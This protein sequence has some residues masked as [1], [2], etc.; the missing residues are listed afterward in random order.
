MVK[1]KRKTPIR[2]K[3]RRHIREGK[4]VQSY[5]RG[6]GENLRRTRS[7]VVRSRRP[8]AVTYADV[9]PD[10]GMLNKKYGTNVEVFG[11]IK[12]RGYSENDIDLISKR[13]MDEDVAWKFADYFNKKYNKKTDMFIPMSEEYRELYSEGYVDEFTGRWIDGV[14]RRYLDWMIFSRNGGF[15][16]GHVSDK[17]LKTISKRIKGLV[18]RDAIL[19]REKSRIISKIIELKDAGVDDNDPRMVLLDQRWVDAEKK[20]MELE[21]A[22]EKIIGQLGPKEAISRRMAKARKTY[23]LTED[24]EWT[25]FEAPTGGRNI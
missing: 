2:H 18:Y 20:L 13:D 23:K 1:R 21:E 14:P 24:R 19:R 3:V 9:V 22:H 8:N 5:Q 15:T 4:R 17:L 6:S 10:L 25:K 7:R 16:R 11:G 12:D